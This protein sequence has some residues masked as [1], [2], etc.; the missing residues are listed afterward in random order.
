MAQVR[1]RAGAVQVSLSGEEASALAALAGQVASM[2]TDDADA[3]TATPKAE[4]DPLEAMVGLSTGSVDA[5]EDPA[6]RRLLPD[7]YGDD[8]AA[9]GEFR[10]L[11]DGELRRQKTEAL[12]EVRAAVDGVGGS[13][14]KLRLAP[15]QAEA[16]LQ[17]LTDIRLVVGTRLDITEDFADPWAQLS[18]DDPQAPLLAAYEWLGWLQESVV[19][20]LED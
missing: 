3:E 8:T 16:W 13:G 6:L 4:V 2:L 19:L 10:R 11:M 7:A 14:T 9:A 18:P 12:D 1:R 5:P 20:A 17:A 15:A